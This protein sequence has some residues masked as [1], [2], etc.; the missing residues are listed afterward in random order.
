MKKF[1]LQLFVF[2]LLLISTLYAQV[3]QRFNYQGIARDA[4]GNPM[5]GQTLSLKITLLPAADA[6]E[7]EYEEM[8]TVTT[9]AFGLYTLQ[10]GNGAPAKGEMKAVTWESG[11]KYIRVAIDPKGG[12]DFVDAGTTQLLSVPYALY[13]ERAGS[14]KNNADR[15]GNVSS[16]AT[17][18]AGDANY[19]SKFTALNVIGKS[20]I[21]DNGTNVGIG[22]NA[23]ASTASLHIRRSTAGQYLYLQNTTA[24]SSGSFRL[25]NDVATNFATFTKYGSAVTGGYTGIADKYPYANILGFGNNGAV[26]NASTGNFGFAITKAGTN[27]LKFHIDAATER[28][29]LGGNATPVAP[30]HFNN[31]NGSNDTLKFTNNTTGHTAADGLEIRTNGNAARI[32]NRENDALVLGTNNTDRLTITGDG[33]MGIGTTAPA[34][35]LDINGQIRIQGG[36]PGVGKVLTSDSA[37]LASWQQATLGTGYFVLPLVSTNV[38]GITSNSATFGGNISNA[39]SNIIEERG[40]VYSTTP[41]PRFQ[42]APKIVLG[43]GAGSFDTIISPSYNDHVLNSNTTYYVRA[44][45]L[46]ENNFIAYGNQV[47]FTTLPV[48]QTGPG[49]G[50]VFFDK[51]DTSGGWQYLEASPMDQGLYTYCAPGAAI[52]GLQFGI[53]SGKANTALI[54]AGCSDSNSAAKQCD[55]LSL[56]GQSDWFLPSPHELF[57]MYK[58]LH[59]NN[60]GGFMLGDYLSSY[61]EV[62]S[63]L[64]FMG[65]WAVIFGFGGGSFSFIPKNNSAGVRAARAF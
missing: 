54:V 2:A 22:T 24:N 29:G 33:N 16:N 60:L 13:A 11:N 21:F 32:I 61:E 63:N 43:S 25:Y 40:I 41:N 30:V 8:Q 14:A 53:G 31:T 47:V 42:S 57:F 1:T 45:A 49:G 19:L 48:G 7:A 34:A 64:P 59:L 36:N 51:G 56:G 4:K 9:N 28:L 18:V 38:S 50:L 55:L 44:Y 5:A 58:N 26:L 10:I 20:Q 15:L 39:N 37:G 17:H 23:P 27:K 52:T 46:T 35:V 6:P 62:P 12:S 65:P 3:P